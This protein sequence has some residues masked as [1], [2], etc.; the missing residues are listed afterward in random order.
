MGLVGAALVGRWAWGLAKD[1]S[2]VLLDAEDHGQMA[3]EVRR[4]VEALPDHEVADLHLWRV[5]PASR[6]CILSLVTHSPRPAA[7]YRQLLAG[8]AGLDHLTVEINE[9]RDA[10]CQVQGTQ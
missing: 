1:S 3:T 4:L 7:Y 8:V 6:A 10:R 9:C 2:E 5:G